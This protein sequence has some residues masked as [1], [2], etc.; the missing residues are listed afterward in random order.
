MKIINVMNFVRQCEPRWEETDKKLFSTTKAQMELVKEMDVEH[1]FLLQYDTLCDSKY[2]D[3]FKAESTEKTELGLWFE[4]VEDMTDAVG[5]PYRS[6]NGWKWDWHIIPGFS[7]GYSVAERELL[8]DEAM[9]KFKE[10]FGVYPKTVGSWLMDT[11][12]IN[13]LTDNYEIS[14][15][16]NCRDQVNTD[17]YTLIGGYFN[18]AYYPSRKNMFTP[19]Q[20]EKLRV[21]VPMFRLLGP[22]PIHNYDDTKYISEDCE[23][24]MSCYT[25]EAAWVGPHPSVADWF[26]KTYYENEDMGFS[27]MQIGQENSFAD[28]DLCSAIRMQ[29]EK[30]KDMPDVRFMKMCDTGEWFK[31]QYE[32]E[33]PVTAVTAL[34]NWDKKDIQSVYYD[35]QY[36]TAN[37]FRYDKDIFLR[38]FYA[39]DENAEDIYLRDVCTT[40]DAV[41]E[42]QPIVDTVIW[43]KEEEKCGIYF[44]HEGEAFS[45][46]RIAEKQLEVSWGDKKV[47]FD[48]QRITLL[49]TG[50]KFYKGKAKA[51]IA[52]KED[53]IEYLYRGREYALQIKG[54]TVSKEDGCIIVVPFTEK[55][56]LEIKISTGDR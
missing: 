17:A 36:Y 19:A 26:F 31:E 7:M 55:M 22:D 24:R 33:T 43:G 50:I 2:T 45:V 35:S 21:N 38:A 29:I 5:L 9:R 30:V 46:K 20:S 40:F 53:A 56:E 23:H 41:Y 51:Q 34:D 15:L 10:V 32:N 39:F 44:D 3:F 1:T 16:C 25:M 47:V 11:H 49:N 4:V 13:Y 27:Y 37:L 48:E 12:T 54:G 14:A 6:E 28:H 8:I 52:I 42:N 18:Q